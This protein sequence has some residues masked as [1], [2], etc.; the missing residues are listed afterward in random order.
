MMYRQRRGC[1]YVRIRTEHI[2]WRLASFNPADMLAP[3]RRG[4]DDDDNI[5]VISRLFDFL[6]QPANISMYKQTCCFAEGVSA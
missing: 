3:L 6:P 4:D 2:D 5:D 1:E